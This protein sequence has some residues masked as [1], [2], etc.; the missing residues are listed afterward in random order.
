MS[1]LIYHK[2]VVII[3]PLGSFPLG[4]Y[5][6]RFVGSSCQGGEKVAD[7]ALRHSLRLPLLL[8]AFQ[9]Q[10]IVCECNLVYKITTIEKADLMMAS[11]RTNP[12]PPQHPSLNLGDPQTSVV[13]NNQHVPNV[14]P[15]ENKP[16]VIFPKDPRV[17]P[18]DPQTSVMENNQH[19]PNVPPLKNKPWVISPK[20]PVSSLTIRRLQLWKTTKTHPRVPRG[21]PMF[22]TGSMS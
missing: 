3:D 1:A 19:V 15:L 6:R 9:R 5:P 21:H 13:E 18:G 8:H 2:C 4:L 20:H 7:V 16:W 17:I 12:T 11:R 22:R 14:P 10:I